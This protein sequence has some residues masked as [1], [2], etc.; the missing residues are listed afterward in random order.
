MHVF[1]TKNT[2]IYAV[3]SKIKKAHQVQQSTLQIMQE[4]C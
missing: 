3:N 4:N 1:K 2:H